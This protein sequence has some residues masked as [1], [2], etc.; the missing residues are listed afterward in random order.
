MKKSSRTFSYGIYLHCRLLLLLWNIFCCL[1]KFCSELESSCWSC[2]IV[3]Y[4]IYVERNEFIC[5]TDWHRLR[6]FQV[7]IKVISI[8]SSVIF[9]PVN[10]SAE[11]HCVLPNSTRSCLSVFGWGETSFSSRIKPMV[12]HMILHMSHS[13]VI[14]N[15]YKVIHNDILFNQLNIWPWQQAVQ[16]SK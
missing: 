7:T 1:L 6:L 4:Y 9:V 14:F 11:S 8:Y 13:E 10:I 2:L 5:L 16:F 3:E 12:V 15:R